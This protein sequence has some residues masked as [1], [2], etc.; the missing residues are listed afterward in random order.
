MAR[1]ER[2]EGADPDAGLVVHYDIPVAWFELEAL[3]QNAR[4]AESEARYTGQVHLPASP[5]GRPAVHSASLT[6]AMNGVVSAPRAGGS[7]PWRL[8]RSQHAAERT[9]RIERAFAAQPAPAGVA[10]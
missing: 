2:A 8:R 9:L 7:F 4:T 10:R 1:L 6:L 3:P 5:R